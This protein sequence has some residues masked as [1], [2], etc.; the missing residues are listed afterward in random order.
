MHWCIVCDGYEMQG[1]RVLVVGN[2]E[3]AAEDA[4]Q[5]LR[6]TPDVALL[7]EPGEHALS[8]RRLRQLEQNG[9]TIHTGRIAGTECR[10]PGWCTSVVTDAGEQIPVDHIFSV[11][12]AVPNTDL[13]AGL[14]LAVDGDGYIRTDTEARTSVPGVYAAGDV[15]RLF[16]HQVITAAHEGATAAMAIAWDLWQREIA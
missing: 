8:S 6:F 15:T 10:D 4:R 13:A 11:L 5:L 14:G 1:Q 12:G 3:V 7:L 2:N 9:V 16:S